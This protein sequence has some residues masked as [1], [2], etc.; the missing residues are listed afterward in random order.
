MRTPP[1]HGMVLV[2]VLVVVAMLTLAGLTFS[3]LMLA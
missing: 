3:A 1:R 2:V